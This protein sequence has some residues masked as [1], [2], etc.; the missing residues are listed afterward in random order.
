MLAARSRFVAN[1]QKPRSPQQ[2]LDESSLAPVAFLSVASKMPSTC[3]CTSIYPTWQVQTAT[4]YSSGVKQTMSCNQGTWWLLKR[5]TCQHPSN[6]AY[7]TLREVFNSC[8]QKD[9]FFFSFD[10]LQDIYQCKLHICRA[11]CTDH[12]LIVAQ[13]RLRV[14]LF[15]VW[16]QN[17]T[18]LCVRHGI[19]I[20]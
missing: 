17:G 13:C 15:I 14:L 12:A 9:I 4:W 11:T 8:L 1:L 3:Q 10:R 18:C 6:Q 16:A 2:I 5:F 20:A 19:Y 7:G